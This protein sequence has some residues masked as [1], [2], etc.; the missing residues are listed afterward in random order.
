MHKKIKIKLFKARANSLNKRSKM[1]VVGFNNKVNGRYFEKLGVFF[2]EGNNT[3]CFINLHRLAFWLNKGAI[4]K[5]KVSWMIG[6][7]AQHNE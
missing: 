4:L 6:F 5:S 3:I 7:L 2:N 1:I